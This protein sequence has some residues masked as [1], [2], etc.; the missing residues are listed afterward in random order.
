MIANYDLGQNSLINVVKITDKSNSQANN[1]D[2]YYQHSA[3]LL[4]T[5]DDQLQENQRELDELKKED[6]VCL[7]KDGNEELKSLNPI[8]KPIQQLTKKSYFFVYCSSKSCK[9]IT[10]GKLRVY[11]SVCKEHT[12]II[13]EGPKSWSDVLVSERVRG[14]CQNFNCKK[15]NNQTNWAVF[16]FKCASDD[17]RN[18]NEEN[19]QSNSQMTKNLDDEKALPLESIKH[20]TRS[21]QCPICDEIKD[22]IFLFKCGHTICLECFKFYCESKLNSR[23]LDLVGNIGYTLNCVFDCTDS[24]IENTHYFHILSDHDYQRY[25]DFAV[26]EFIRNNNGLFCPNPNCSQGML[27]DENVNCKKICCINCEFVFCKSCKL[28][29]HDGECSTDIY[30]ESIKVNQTNHVKSFTELIKD[31]MNSMN[32]FNWNRN[33]PEVKE[34]EIKNCPNCKCPTERDSG[35]VHVTCKFCRLDWC[36][37]CVKEFSYDCMSNHWFE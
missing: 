27:L 29:Y 9:K 28:E 5:N 14:R 15:T 4:T 24:Y 16:Y 37:L 35:C 30:L 33:V 7:N 19:E 12:L 36:F 8:L 34:V 26:E 21:I 1:P 2:Q 10:N 20:N 13:N 18:E 6:F 23:E 32:V 3:L 25:Q 22:I 31:K 17:H 11:C